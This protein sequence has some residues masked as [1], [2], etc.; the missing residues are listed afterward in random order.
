[1]SS[2]TDNA[3]QATSDMSDAVTR[4]PTRDAGTNNVLRL[5]R[6]SCRDRGKLFDQLVCDDEI[7]SS[8][9]TSSRTSAIASICT[10]KSKLRD[11]DLLSVEVD[12]CHGEP[13]FARIAL[14]APC[15]CSPD[16]SRTRRRA[17]GLRASAVHAHLL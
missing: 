1:M 16:R 15:C 6:S 7:V 14:T 17:L 2:Q 3:T 11:H 5:T 8:V 12:A 13:F 10:C 9:R 4:E